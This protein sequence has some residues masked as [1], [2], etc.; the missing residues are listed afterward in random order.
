M[1]RKR[2][3]EYAQ[4]LFL[5]FCP[6]IATTSTH[7]PIKTTLQQEGFD[8]GLTDDP[9]YVRDRREGRYRRIDSA[10]HEQIVSGAFRL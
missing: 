8:P 5:R 6:A 1:I 2:L 3:P 9:L 4:P 7:K 10:L